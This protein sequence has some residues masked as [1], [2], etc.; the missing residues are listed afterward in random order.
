MGMGQESRMG[1]VYLEDHPMTCKWL[2]TMDHGDRVV[3][4]LS[5]GFFLMGVTSTYSPGVWMSR[6]IN[7][8][9]I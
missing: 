5:N 6:D 1:H 4:P 7:Q 8:K 2:I 9:H 3:G